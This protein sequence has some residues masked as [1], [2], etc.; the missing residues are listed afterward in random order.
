MRHEQVG[1][2]ID[3]VGGVELAIDTD[4]EGLLSELVDDIEHAAGPPVMGS[5]LDEVIGSHCPA[6]H[7]YM[8]ERRTWF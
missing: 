3:D 6:G 4:H 5:V 7:V 1:Q 8:P 2:S